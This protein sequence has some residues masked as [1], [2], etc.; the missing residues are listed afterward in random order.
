MKK[1]IVCALTAA[2]L[3][4][5]PLTGCAEREASGTDAPRENAEQQ[6]PPAAAPAP[7]P[8]TAP[9][10][11]AVPGDEPA[12]RRTP[13]FPGALKNGTYPIAV[14]CDSPMFKITDCELTVESGELDAMS[15]KMTLS[16]DSYGYLY[17]GT[18]EEA[19]AAGTYAYL[20]PTVE[21]G[22]GTFTLHVNALDQ[23]TACAA[24]SRD[25]EQWYDRTLVFR[26]D[27]LP[28]DAFKDEAP[29]AAG[30]PGLRDGPY[31][32]KVT[33][34][35]G[36]GKA[37]VWEMAQLWVQDGKV[38]AYITWMSANYDYMLVDGVRYD[39]EVVDGVSR[40]SEIPVAAFDRPLAVIA[41]TTAMGKPHEIEYTLTFDSSTLRH[42]QW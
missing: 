18:A 27:S 39:S 5:A 20:E 15:A 37:G 13:L 26:S 23:E 7:A 21:N 1:W 34:G 3:A 8:D 17:P 38:L 35:G 12:P 33:L 24:W 19:A 31:T 9:A 41:D 14:D 25:K 10:P 42:F 32:A 29:M 22:V 6:T 28:V 16:S 40:F 4:A 36:S 11:E 2:L 30:I